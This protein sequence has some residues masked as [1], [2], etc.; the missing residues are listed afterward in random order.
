MYFQIQPMAGESGGTKSSKVKWVAIG[1]IVVS[2]VVVAG[3][4]GAF[5]FMYKISSEAIKVL[6]AK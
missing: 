1:A 3:F 5:V 4:V 6:V 2:I